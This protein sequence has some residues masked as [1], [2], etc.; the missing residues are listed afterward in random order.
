MKKVCSF[1]IFLIFVICLTG[2]EKSPFVTAVTKGLSFTAQIDC[3]DRLIICDVVIDKNGKG[4]YT[5]LSPENFNYSFIFDGKKATVKYKELTHN[6][7]SAP[8]NNVFY[9]LNS[10]FEYIREN[11][12]EPSQKDKLYTFSGKT[13]YGSF[14]LITSQSG[15]PL[16]AEIGNIKVQF[17]DVSII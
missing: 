1:I 9:I 10:V 17:K 5:A 14:K 12:C 2:C 6:I 11:E 4:T 3:E 15:L 16:N 8:Y 7:D 13:K